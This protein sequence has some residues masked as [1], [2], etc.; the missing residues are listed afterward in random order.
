MKNIVNQVNG[1][2]KCKK[3]IKDEDY[4]I[5]EIIYIW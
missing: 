3:K 2:R 4:I 1:F 5:E